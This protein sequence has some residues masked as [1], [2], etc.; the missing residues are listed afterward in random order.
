MALRKLTDATVEPVT[1]AEAKAQ[2]NVYDS[3][4]DVYI[5][6]LITASRMACEHRIRRTFI[7]TEWELTLD[8][9]P[10]AIPL[11]MSRVR[12]V[13][14]VKYIDTNGTLQTLTPSTG[15]FVDDRS[16]P[17]WIVPAFGTTWPVTL[18]QINSV[19]VVYRCGYG[20]DATTVPEPI[21]LWIKMYLATAFDNR[22]TEAVEPGLVVVKLDF[23]DHLLD[24]FWNVEL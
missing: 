4:R 1:L 9:F 7:D 19:T 16:E 5:T 10:C 13:T 2:C 6:S 17:G 22:Q 11:R 24:E 8:R 23:A 18:D 21:K 14:S 20:V 15:Y 3:T 12:S